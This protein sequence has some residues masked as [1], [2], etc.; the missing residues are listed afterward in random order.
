MKLCNLSISCNIDCV[1]F[2]HA[3]FN[4]LLFSDYRKTL[5]IE[6]YGIKNVII[7]VENSYPTH[8][9]FIL[10]SFVQV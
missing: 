1:V 6:Y 10:Y 9:I 3:P 8:L 5:T 2:L 4:L 7:N